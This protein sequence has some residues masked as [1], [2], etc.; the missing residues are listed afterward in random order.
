MKDRLLNIIDQDKQWIRVR[1][2]GSLKKNTMLMIQ[3]DIVKKMVWM[4]ILKY[5]SLSLSA[6]AIFFSSLFW[7]SHSQKEKIVL[8]YPYSGETKVEVVGSFN[9]WDSR[10]NMSLDKEGVFWK[11]ELQLKKG[12]IYEYQFIIDEMIYTTGNAENTISGNNDSD[13]ALLFI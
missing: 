7:V 11:V 12:R 4:R 13:K 9:N 8:M 3:H 10:L 2:P 5:G 1:T 6:L